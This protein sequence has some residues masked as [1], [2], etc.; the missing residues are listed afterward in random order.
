MMI[1]MKIGLAAVVVVLVSY[2][3]YVVGTSHEFVGVIREDVT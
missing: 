3:S 2:F 1:V